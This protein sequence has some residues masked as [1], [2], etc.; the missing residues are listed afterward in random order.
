[1]GLGPLGGILA[2][3]ISCEYL[4]YQNSRPG[5]DATT[6]PLSAKAESSLSA[7]RR[8]QVFSSFAA[9]EQQYGGTRLGFLEGFLSELE[10]LKSGV[11]EEEE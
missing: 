5:S 3:N 1:M 2:Q 9:A 8:E 10:N 6:T 7:A 11:V 4:F